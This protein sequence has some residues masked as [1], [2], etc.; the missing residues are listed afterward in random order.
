MAAGAGQKL[1]G[2]LPR[3]IHTDRWFWAN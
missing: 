3:L 1:A 2:I